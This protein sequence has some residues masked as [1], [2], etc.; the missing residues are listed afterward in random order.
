MSLLN[1]FKL[2]KGA[3]LN[4]IVV[5][6]IIII[7]LAGTVIGMFY[8]IYFNNS[9][10]R[11]NA[12]AVNYAINILEYTDKIPY[13]DVKEDIDFKSMFNIPDD[14]IVLFEVKKYNEDDDTKED[15]IK[16]VKL[17]VKYRLQDNEEEFYISKL[18]IKEI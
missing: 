9:M 6:M 15:V 13:D 3:T 18:K 8:K 1:K 2:N 10:I 12:M 17:T 16:T 7:I 4:D 14:F 11:M 5:A